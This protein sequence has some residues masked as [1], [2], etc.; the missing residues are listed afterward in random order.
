MPTAGEVVAVDSL[1]AGDV[2]SYVGQS[3]EWTVTFNARID[4]AGVVFNPN[5]ALLAVVPYGNNVYYDYGT[6]FD[7]IYRGHVVF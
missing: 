3:T 2:F 7:V 6:A 1:V 5:L 4:S